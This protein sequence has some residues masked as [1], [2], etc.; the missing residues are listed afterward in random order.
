MKVV[1]EDI[2]IFVLGHPEYLNLYHSTSIGYQYFCFR[3]LAACPVG[4]GVHLE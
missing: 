2:R 1:K 4:T 3:C